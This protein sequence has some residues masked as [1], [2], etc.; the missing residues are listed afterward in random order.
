MVKKQ[1]QLLNIIIYVRSSIIVWY[2]TWEISIA[3]IIKQVY[4]LY[5]YCETINKLSLQKNAHS[6]QSETVPLNRHLDSVKLWC[7]NCELSIFSTI[8][9]EGQHIPPEMTTYV[10]LSFFQTNLCALVPFQLSVRIS[11]VSFIV[12]LVSFLCSA[13]CVLPRVGF[14]RYT[15]THTYTE[16]SSGSS[17]GNVVQ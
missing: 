8:H 16:G 1:N 7:H 6:L 13:L 3:V 4:M 5:K 9:L 2:S 14:S 10:Y 15:H 12:K 11:A 17:G